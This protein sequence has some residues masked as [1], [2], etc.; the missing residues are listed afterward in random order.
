M[1][2]QVAWFELRYQLKSPVLWTTL[3][4][5]FLAGFIVMADDTLQ[6]GALGNAYKNGP[7]AI[8]LLI[9]NMAILA[10]F[11]V[12]AFVCNVVIRDWD[13]G[14]GAILHATRIRKS[15]YLIGRFAGALAASAIVLLASPLGMM[16]GAAMPWLDPERFGSF[17]LWHY[18]Y[19]FLV[20]GLPT[21]FLCAALFFALATATRSMM[22][23]Y[24]GLI[25]FLIFYVVLNGI[26]SRPQYQQLSALLE[27]YGI[28]ALMQET[29]YWTAADRNAQLIPLSRVYLANRAIWGALALAALLT[30][31][32]TF[33]FSRG[34]GKIDK[35]RR[36]G[37]P[38]EAP[39][40]TK[41]KVTP[42]R[43]EFGSSAAFS[44]ML[45]RIRFEAFYVFSSPAFIVLMGFGLFNAAGSLWLADEGPG[46]STVFPMT[47]LMAKTLI[48]SFT[49]IPIII[50]TYYSGEL[51]WRDHEKR[52]HEVIDS[53]PAA[54]WTF[55]IPKVLAL[56]LVLA[57]S[58]AVSVVAGIMVQMLKGFHD[59]NVPGYLLWYAL[60]AFF[61]SFC[62]VALA[63]FLQAIS[64]NKFV[65]WG[66]MVVYLLAILVS[67][68]MGFDHNLYL[69]GHYPSVPISE[70]NGQGHYWIGAAWFQ[71]YWTLGALLLVTLAY[72]LWR[73]GADTR[74]LPRLRALPQRLAGVART[75]TALLVV[76]FVSCGAWIFYNTSILNTYRS[77][78]AM[79]RWQADMERTL[80]RY[81][82]APMPKTS[83]VTLTVDLYPHQHRAITVGVYQIE[84]RTNAPLHEIYLFWPQRVII[85]QAE[86]DGA[87]LERDF[88]RETPAFPFQIWHL[89]QPMQPGERRRI[90]FVT[91]L[92]YPGFRNND[93]LTP[94]NDD[95]TFVNASDLTP[96][97]GF[98][99]SGLLRD[100]NLRRRQ[101]LP[102][103]LRVPRLEDE[104]ARAVNYVRHDSDWV[105]ADITVST[106]A[107]QTPIAPGYVVSDTTS[108]GRRTVHYRTDAPILQFFS[109]QSAV[110]ETARERWGNVDLA[111]YYDR[112]HTYN[113][114]RMMRAM[115]VSLELFSRKFS[116]FQFHQLRIIEF[117]AYSPG[118]QS[119]ANTVPFSESLGFT[120]HFNDVEGAREAD[121]IDIN[122]Y[123]TAHEI[124]HQWWGHQVIGSDQQGVTM[125]SETFAQYSALLVMEEI[126]GRDQVRRFLR[127]ELDTYLRGRNAEVV[128]EEPLAR[129][130]N[131]PYIHYNKGGVVM[132]FLRNELGEEVVNRS[133]ARLLREFAFHGA[134]YPRSIDF[135]RILR[136]EAGPEHDALIT[137]LFE[138]ITLYDARVLEA[139]AVRSKEGRWDVTMLVEAHKLYADGKGVETEAPL[140]E[141]FEIGVFAAEPGEGRFTSNDVITM[142][143]Q[144]I[145]SGVQKLT[146]SVDREPRFAGID[147]YNMRID[148]NSR[149]NVGTVRSRLGE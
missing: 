53:T 66:L 117:P 74:L 42:T 104:D 102:A 127:F 64:P 31:Y 97:I 5:F 142:A 19:A 56:L 50:A 137:D 119:F 83:D 124:A 147:P 76:G 96:L 149:D 131:Q 143:R 60:P 52:I 27:P 9:G 44:Q 100:R 103:D 105:N 132:Y 41:L 13:T 69:Y 106:V 136:E 145:R 146:L 84:N 99:R 112:R 110:Y 107:D 148:R 3:A 25:A 1:F 26:L 77:S 4:A 34:V 2:G 62:S 126:Y 92:E 58:I 14:F 49:F 134:P 47:S 122:T 140:D 111:I 63:V 81:E 123:A 57:A 139:S 125:L 129:V 30:A 128:E 86:I 78:V 94:I 22:G 35:K 21:L 109:V 114:E 46:H 54:N 130:E 24:L 141:T 118:A 121:R 6:I 90:Q 32:L 95:G 61:T 85:D 89:S 115:K 23:S 80:L 38:R 7:F 113:I 65:G 48:D 73:R 138:R 33:S 17:V 45:A 15:D 120:T 39:T 18:V 71:L 116:A 16:I 101:G 68:Q 79:Q 51:V 87:V 75:I 72:T 29:R 20:A 98:D 88:A 70:M 91:R 144:R 82:H 28:G 11:A 67:G 37:V 93:V 36:E 10:Q 108:N 43:K 133:L 59:Y 135:L 12:V 8:T 55:V 40:N